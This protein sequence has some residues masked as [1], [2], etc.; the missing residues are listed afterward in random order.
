MQLVETHN[1]ALNF[2]RTEGLG[3]FMDIVTLTKLSRR[4]DREGGLQV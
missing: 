1:T 4:K 2:H 3:K